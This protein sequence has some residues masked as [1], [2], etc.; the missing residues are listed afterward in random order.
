MDDAG[1]T[2]GGAPPPG[3]RRRR[4]SWLL[5]GTVLF[6]A[7]NV[8]GIGALA[9]RSAAR[10]DGSCGGGFSGYS[11]GGGDCRV[12][13]SI[14]NVD[15]PDP[16]AVHG[17][18]VYLLEVTN[19]SSFDIGQVEVQDKLPAS[20]RVDWVLPSSRPYSDCSVQANAVFCDFYGFSAHQK[21]AVAIVARPNNPGRF[22]SVATA[23]GFFTDPRPGNNR[24]VARTTVH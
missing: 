8:L 12:D 5:K 23:S 15:V 13:V 17:R 2:S 18:L 21:A 14:T 11:G 4:R 19:N 16:V 1:T 6:V 3:P 7:V 22:T 10:P 9:A 20:F 24:A